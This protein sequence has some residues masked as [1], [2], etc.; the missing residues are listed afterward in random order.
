M[1]RWDEWM[2]RELREGGYL[3]RYLAREKAMAKVRQR[4]VGR[5]M[6]GWRQNNK[7]DL[8]LKAAIPAREFFRWK[9]V[10]KDF[11]RDE[12]N[13]RSLKRDNPELKIYV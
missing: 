1:I 2:W 4:A 11:W 12:S 8:E 3:Q 13:L 5:R 7:S 6:E 10:D 9:A